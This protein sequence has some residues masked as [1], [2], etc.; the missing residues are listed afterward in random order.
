VVFKRKN[1]KLTGLGLEIYYEN[2]GDANEWDFEEAIYQLKNLGEGWRFPTVNEMKYLDNLSDLGVLHL[3]F[4]SYWCWNGKIFT[5][6]N[7]AD[8]IFGDDIP[9]YNIEE[10]GINW[11]GYTRN[12]N[13]SN[14]SVRPVRNIK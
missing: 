7:R 4:D 2:L 3:Y 11:V 10:F 13:F 1:I 6:I 5:D 9:H 14:K 8:F 12:V